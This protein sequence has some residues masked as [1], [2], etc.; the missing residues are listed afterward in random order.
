MATGAGGGPGR[1]T[2]LGSGDGSALALPGG[3]TGEAAEYAG[4]Y[5]LL[6]R[7]LH[8]AL[9]Y[10]SSARRRGASGTV[11]LLV[12]IAPSGAIGAVVLAVSS[13][14][15]V[16][17]EAAL[18]AMRSVK[19]VPFPPGVRPRALSVRMPVVFDLR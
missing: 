10:P 17:D 5:A 9:R 19:Q 1:G 6:R 8:E 12:D 3:G 2:G 15:S 13:S 16:L 4:Y 14:H 18:D 11:E 7:R